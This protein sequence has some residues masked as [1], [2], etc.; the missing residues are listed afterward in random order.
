MDDGAD[1]ADDDDDDDDDVPVVS[2]EEEVEGR[3]LRMLRMPAVAHRP[4]L[5]HALNLDC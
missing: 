1:D 3:L 5:S 2:D 4:L